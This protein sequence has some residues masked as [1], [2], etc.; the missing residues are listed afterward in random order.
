MPSWRKS[1]SR[2]PRYTPLDQVKSDEEAQLITQFCGMHRDALRNR[3]SPTWTSDIRRLP[4]KLHPTAIFEVMRTE[5]AI[6]DELTGCLP[7][8][9]ELRVKY[10]QAA[11]AFKKLYR[12]LPSDSKVPD[13][14][15]DQYQVLKMVKSSGQAQLLLAEKMGY[16]QPVA[17]KLALDFNQNARLNLEAHLL[18][19]VVH[20]HIAKCLD[21]GSYRSRT[22]LVMEYYVGDNFQD[23][24]AKTKPDA[25]AATRM[26]LQIARGVAHLHDLK[27]AHRD[28]KPENCFWDRSS[29]ARLLD[30]GCAVSFNEAMQPRRSLSDNEGTPAYQSPEQIEERQDADP[31]FGDIYSL[32]ALFYFLLTAEHPKPV[33]FENGK[34]KTVEFS[35]ARPADCP[36]RLWSICEKARAFSPCNRY[37]RTCDLVAA[38]EASLNEA[39]VAQANSGKNWARRGGLVAAAA[40]LSAI[41]FA[42]PS[43]LTLFKPAPDLASSEKPEPSS[44]PASPPENMVPGDAADRI[45]QIVTATDSTEPEQQDFASLQE[46]M[47]DLVDMAIQSTPPPTGYGM[48]DESSDSW[49]RQLAEDQGIDLSKI[50]ADAFRLSVDYSNNA[51]STHK[52]DPLTSARSKVFLIVDVDD[53]LI[54][55]G[56]ALEYRVGKRPWRHIVR[57]NNGKYFGN[58]DEK[59][60]VSTE[61]VRLRLDSKVGFETGDIIGPFDTDFVIAEA[62]RRLDG[63]SIKEGAALAKKMKWVRSTNGTWS[64]NPLAFD[65]Y[66]HFVK[67]IRIGPSHD[68][69]PY[70]IPLDPNEGYRPRD[71]NLPASGQEI[72]TKQKEDFHNAVRAM[73]NPDVICT[74]VT[75]LDGSKPLITWH[76]HEKR[77]HQRPPTD[78]FNYPKEGFGHH[79]SPREE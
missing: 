59:D 52:G 69:F 20:P 70:S 23:H 73:N 75:Y 14:I 29:H 71:Y 33:E 9:H 43:M 32:G 13:R 21:S 3:V 24:V 45:K 63:Q 36:P 15:K 1:K 49:I 58:L 16:S 30:L 4:A 48:P 31:E 35:K 57:M 10:P 25:I 37:L 74:K 5:I 17:I 51:F 72:N 46:K 66:W 39:L 18:S 47:N 67:E 38:L 27:I 8:L 42:V 56:S 19:S 79:A 12:H 78:N 11:K 44:S 64:L 54:D 6:Q 34:T 50:T 26:L 77:Y 65:K 22:Y 68:E 55:F 61:K 7:T 62:V 76:E 53:K 40:A 41:L 2:M 28:I 60:L